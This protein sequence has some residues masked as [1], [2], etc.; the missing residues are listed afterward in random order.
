[1]TESLAQLI[2]ENVLSYGHFRKIT[3]ES[4]QDDIYLIVDH[5]TVEIQVKSHSTTFVPKINES[6]RD[7]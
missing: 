5:G 6:E 1:M 7:L 4:Q 3:A 2:T